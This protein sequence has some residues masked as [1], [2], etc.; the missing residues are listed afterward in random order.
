MPGEYIMKL[1]CVFLYFFIF[2]NLFAVNS[3]WAADIYV[4]QTLSIDCTNGNYS[5]SSRNC[6]GSDGDAY[7]IV[8]EA[9]DNMN[10]GDDIYLRGGTYGNGDLSA[11]STSCARI[12]LTKNGTD[13]GGDNLFDDSWS[14]IQSYPGEWAILDGENA[15][16]Q[17]YG[18]VLGYSES[19][20]DRSTDIQYWKFERMELTRGSYNNSGTYSTAGLWVNGGP[21]IARYLY[22]HDNITSNTGSNPGGLMTYQPIN[23]V[24]E[25][26]YFK[27][28][29]SNVSAFEDHSS[30]GIVTFAAYNHGVGNWDESDSQIASRI[31]YEQQKNEFR[32]NIIDNANGYS[33][34][35]FFGKGRTPL[36]NTGNPQW[37]YEEY[38]D[39]YHHNIILNTQR[40][41]DVGQQFAQVYNNIVSVGTQDNT[42]GIVFIG[43]GLYGAGHGNAAYNN[44]IINGRLMDNFGYQLSGDIVDNGYMSFLNNLFASPPADYSGSSTIQIGQPYMNTGMTV[45]TSRWNHNSNYV[46]DP[47]SSTHVD[48]SRLTG[49]CYGEISISTYD[50]CYS[51]TNYTKASSEGN[52]NLF[53]GASGADQ[54]IT[55]GAHVVSGSDTI[56]DAGVGGN[57]PYLSGITIPS[58]IGATNP[59]DNAW[60]AGVLGLTNIDTLK[61]GPE[62][63]PTW[64]EGSGGQVPVEDVPG[65]VWNIRE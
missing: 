1:K 45:D 13:E 24:V 53:S 17:G 33:A 46:Y 18:G 36:D 41:I 62:G 5:I 37:T 14:S 34:Y 22:I 4:D 52:D 25:F 40:G 7:N 21:F 35:G 47:T 16:G 28:N 42:S 39:K 11:S 50:S 30:A 54:Y 32:Y 44:T 48:A 61:N 29:G 57:H 51:A 55:R 2:L 6:S 64:V 38:G 20:H 60:V 31:Q 19:A 65:K 63:N 23:S 56:A 12:P 59:N 27:N 43:S 58:Y 49:A 26:C 8:Q 15:C 9:L 3:I 10:G